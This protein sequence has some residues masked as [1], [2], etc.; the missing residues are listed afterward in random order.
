VPLAEVADEAAFRALVRA[1]FAQRRKTLRNGLLGADYAAGA[2]D[3]A[4][5]ALGL[6]PTVRGETLTIPQLAALCDALAAH[7]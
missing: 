7:G 6:V 3:A 5:A 1:V 2:V 4:L